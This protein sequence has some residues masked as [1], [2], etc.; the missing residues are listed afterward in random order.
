MTTKTK[1]YLNFYESLPEAKMRIEGTVV[2]YDSDPYY[3][4]CVCE[5]HTDD[6]IFRV[7]LDPLPTGPGE[8]MS[9]ER[10]SIPYT[11]HDEPGMPRSK[12]M[13]MWYD[14][15]GKSTTN[16]VR[17]KM[18]S[19]LFNRFRPFPLG[20]VYHHDIVTYTERKP[21]RYTQQGL[22]D[23]MLSFH[24]ITAGL[25]SRAGKPSML[26]YHLRNTIKGVYPTFEECQQ[27][28]SDDKVSNTAAAFHRD[29]ALVKGPLGLLYLAYKQDLVGFLPAG[30]G[31]EVK[32]GAQFT[33]LR[34]V[35][36]EV[37]LTTTV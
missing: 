12:K 3:V 4:L 37:G 1:E 20:M 26:S 27:A 24:A 16:V 18:N 11:W 17:K 13:A 29:F 7:Y 28:L 30:Q 35:V 6:G 10:F 25:P 36:T 8:S 5:S 14:E 22:I 32:L 23:S 31:R 21:C 34:E 9:H 33:H 19:P 15:G 2:L